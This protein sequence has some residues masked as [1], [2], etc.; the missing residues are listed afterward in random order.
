MCSCVQLCACRRTLA[1]ILRK[2]TSLSVH[3]SNDSGKMV[4]NDGIQH[5]PCSMVL[6]YRKKTGK[7]FSMMLEMSIFKSESLLINS[8]CGRN[9]ADKHTVT[10]VQVSFPFQWRFYLP[11]QINNSHLIYTWLVHSP[12]FEWAFWSA[13]VVPEVKRVCGRCLFQWSRVKIS[14]IAH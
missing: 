4:W 1:L 7:E 14:V 3:I 11:F 13:S 2:N 8:V 9:E 12:L 6:K 10:G 5:T